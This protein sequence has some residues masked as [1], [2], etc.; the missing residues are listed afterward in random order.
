MTFDPCRIISHFEGHRQLTLRG[1]DYNKINNA[2]DIVIISFK[3]CFGFFIL[4]SEVSK[5]PFTSNSHHMKMTRNGSIHTVYHMRQR[6][7][8]M[9]MMKSSKT[10]ERRWLKIPAFGAVTNWQNAWDNLLLLEL[11]LFSLQWKTLS[12]IWWTEL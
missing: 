9:R 11:S 2:F 7:M 12:A 3:S 6:S 4:F 8:T 1:S 5:N 10:M